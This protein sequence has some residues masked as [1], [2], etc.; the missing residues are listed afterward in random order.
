MMQDTLKGRRAIVVC[1]VGRGDGKKGGR[2]VVGGEE[3]SWA[4]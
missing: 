4:V 2:W 1:D 3:R